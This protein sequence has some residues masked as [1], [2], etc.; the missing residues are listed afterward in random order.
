MSVFDV[1][2]GIMIKSLCTFRKLHLLL[3]LL[4]QLAVLTFGVAGTGDKTECHNDKRPL[5]PC[6]VSQ[7]A[8]DG[9]WA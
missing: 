3:N 7:D 2:T 8:D 6:S 4:H 1:V 9:N 5:H